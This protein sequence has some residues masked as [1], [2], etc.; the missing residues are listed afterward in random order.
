MKLLVSLVLLLVAYSSFAKEWFESLAP[1]VTRSRVL[2][3]AGPPSSSTNN[4]DI[5]QKPPGR[6]ECI[7][8]DETLRSAIYY[9][10]PDGALEWCL[11]TRI[12]TP[13]SADLLQ[14]MQFLSNTNYIE[15]PQLSGPNIYTYK[16]SG[17]CYEVEGGFLVME[18]IITMGGGIGC[19]TN[20]TAR[21]LFV[22]PDGSEQVI[23][24]AADHWQ[25]L[26]PAGITALE[27]ERRTSIVR[28][29]GKRLIGKRV[30]KIL[31]DEDS[32]EGCGVDCRLYYIEDGLLIVRCIG[33]NAIIETARIVRPGIATM[34]VDKWIKLHAA[35][36][37][38]DGT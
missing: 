24:R 1:G 28:Q 12:G 38:S 20:K 6:I 37:G 26:R 13:N 8:E 29:L 10:T 31:G 34:S 15:I 11:Y 18:P 22:K 3:V 21:L 32:H 9:N 35:G 23:Y 33:S 36:A 4:L 7:Y 5:Y 27:A 19:F 25:V 16:Y 17:T 30:G 14:R 2:Q